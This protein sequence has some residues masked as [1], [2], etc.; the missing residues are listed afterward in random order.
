[1]HRI[2][3]VRAGG[4]RIAVEKAFGIQRARKHRKLHRSRIRSRQSAGGAHG[5]CCAQRIAKAVK[6]ICACPQAGGIDFGGK[7]VGLQRIHL[8]AA[9]HAGKGTV[10]GNLPVQRHR[11]IAAINAG[12]RP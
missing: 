7:A 6:I 11:C 1:M 10:R 8:A 5:G 9:D 3:R 12:V 4:I 2:E